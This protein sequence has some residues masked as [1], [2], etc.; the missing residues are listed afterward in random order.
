[1]LKRK[2]WAAQIVLNFC[3]KLNCYAPHD[4]F[5]TGIK[6]AVKVLPLSKG[7]VFLSDRGV[8]CGG[9]QG[10]IVGINHVAYLKMELPTFFGREH[11]V[12]LPIVLLVALRKLTIEL[13]LALVVDRIVF[14]EPAAS[15]TNGSDFFQYR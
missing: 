6:T 13:S 2:N 10:C 11:K 1:M 14:L 12:L 7:T 5:S 8:F 3:W 9:R 15:K 4:V